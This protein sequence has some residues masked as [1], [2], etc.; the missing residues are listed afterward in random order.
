MRPSLAEAAVLIPLFALEDDLHMLFTLRSTNLSRHSGQVSF[1]GG[2]R[3]PE[4][5]DRLATALRESYE[6]IGLLG[7]HVEPLGALDDVITISDFLVTPYVARIDWP[8]ELLP[9]ADEIADVFTVPLSRLLDTSLWSIEERRVSSRRFYPVYRFL[10][11]RHDV[12][13]VTGNMVVH[14]LEVVFDWGHPAYDPSRLSLP[15]L[16]STAQ[17]RAGE[18]T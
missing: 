10:G 11:G 9:S 12:W 17:A 18:G 4:D 16:S 3:Q 2:G 15:H 5:R 8:L 7:R 14:F 6:E 1:P 13:G